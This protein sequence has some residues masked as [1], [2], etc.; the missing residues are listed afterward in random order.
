MKAPASYAS[1]S[2]EDT[3]AKQEPGDSERDLF[4]PETWGA[5]VTWLPRCAQE[6]L[7]IDACEFTLRSHFRNHIG[8]CWSLELVRRATPSAG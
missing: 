8:A 3:H 6:S 5:A 1:K 4:M 2:R 7:V